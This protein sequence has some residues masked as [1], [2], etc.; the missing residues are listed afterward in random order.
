MTTRPTFNTT[1]FGNSDAAG[2]PIDAREVPDAASEYRSPWAPPVTGSAENTGPGAAPQ[3]PPGEFGHTP[4]AGGMNPATGPV[5]VGPATGGVPT[6]TVFNTEGTPGPNPPTGPGQGSPWGP[7]PSPPSPPW[8][9]GPPSGQPW[10]APQYPPPTGGYGSPAGG[11]PGGPVGPGGPGPGPARSGPLGG[12]RRLVAAAV[13]LVLVSGGIGGGVGALVADNSGSSQV[14]TGSGLTRDTDNS[15]VAPAADGT[16]SKAAQ[17]ILPSV[18]T[19]SEVSSSEAGTGSGVII[20]ADGYILTNNHVVSGASSGGSLTVT[21]QTGEQLDA[22]VVGTD[23]SSD[24]AVVKIN[25]TGL[26][27][28]TFGDS[29]ALQIGELVVAVGSPLGLSGTV[30]SGIVSAVHRPVRTGDSQVQDQNAVLDAIQTDTAI[31]PGNSGGP[32]VNSK[33]QIVGINSAIATVDS[34]SG[35]GQQQQSGNIGVGFAIGS[36]YAQKI[37]EQLIATGHATHPYLG[38]S[39]SDVGNGNN[40]QPSTS[41]EGAQIRSLVGG[42]PAEQAGLQVGDIITKLDDRTVTDTDSLIA[43]V[44]A[45]EVNNNVTVTYSRDG[46]TRTVQVKL[47]QQP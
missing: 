1:A 6:N 32:L 22:T 31:N 36:N 29:D 33:G 34:G 7:P 4:Y 20:R 41:S 46:Q 30:T 23:P 10:A 12:R 45:H 5:L 26:T 13:A 47:A 14:V 11:I 25:K 3:G 40:N 28:A 15:P 35:L 43:A 19:I 42:G 27:A 39:A 18:V 17:V 8:S 37:A 24:L 38:V 44:R 9:A 21:L 2:R 16:V